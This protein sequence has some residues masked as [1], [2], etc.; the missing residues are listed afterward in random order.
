VA[1][2]FKGVKAFQ[3]IARDLRQKKNIEEERKKNLAELEKINKYLVGRELKMRELKKE[4]A[5][6]KQKCA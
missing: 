4:I 5:E 3:V 1:I 2:F 6:L